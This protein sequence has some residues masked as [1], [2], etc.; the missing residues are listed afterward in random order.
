MIRVNDV[1]N[2]IQGEGL[3]TGVPMTLLRLHGCSVG[4]PWCDTKETWQNGLANQHSALNEC[5]GANPRWCEMTEDD[6]V[7][8]VKEQ[9]GGPRWV[10][11]T[12]GEPAEQKIG[13]LCEKLIR[14]GRSVALETSGTADVP[15]YAVDHLTVSP[16]IDM[17]GGRFVLPEVLREAHEIK[18]PVGSE[19]DIKTLAYT[20]DVFKVSRRIPVYLQPLS[21]SDKAT[22]LCIDAATANGWR[23]S[24]QVHKYHGVR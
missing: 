7:Q 20:L 4:C 2:T 1:Y 14:S 18:W 19:K 23:V 13:T 21:T 24:L 11:L 9:F 12:G 16:K 5:L 3:H 17:P 22:A 6:L 10:L 15:L 8:V